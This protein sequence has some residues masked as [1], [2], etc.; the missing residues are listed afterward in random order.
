MSKVSL[1]L[2]DRLQANLSDQDFL[3]AMRNRLLEL[4]REMA[5]PAALRWVKRNLFRIAEARTSLPGLDLKRLL[6]LAGKEARDDLRNDLRYPVSYDQLNHLVSAAG[7]RET[8][9]DSA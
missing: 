1:G 9:T 2:Y 6:R 4:E 5:A 3:I 8:A 7:A